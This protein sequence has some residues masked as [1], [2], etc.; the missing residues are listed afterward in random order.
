MK[1]NILIILGVSALVISFQNC[2][3][4]AFQFSEDTLGK[5]SYESSRGPLVV[6]VAQMIEE[7]ELAQDLV[8][9]EGKQVNEHDEDFE[10]PKNSVMAEDGQERQPASSDESCDHKNSEERE[11]ASED[12]NKVNQIIEAYACGNGSRGSRKVYVCHHPQ[13]NPGHA[14]TLCVGFPA[15]RALLMQGK[16]AQKN[17]L[18]Q[19]LN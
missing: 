17:Y 9:Q 11:I 2:S 14:H 16:D 4:T 12:D 5:A 3:Q 18:G 6:D 19:C 13:G 7:Q 10:N 1:R 8:H 15:A